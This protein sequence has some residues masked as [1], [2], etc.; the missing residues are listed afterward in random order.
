MNIFKILAN[1]HGSINENNVSAFLGYLLDP[2]GDHGLG[3]EFLEH[4]LFRVFEDEDFKFRK[5]DYEVILEQGF[6][7]KEK[8]EVV[9]IVI[10]CFS[11]NNSQ[12]SQS[13]FKSIIKGEAKIEKVFLIENKIKKS[14]FKAEQ[15]KKQFESFKNEGLDVKDEDIHSILLS[16]HEKKI[17]DTFKTHKP[18]N[19][20]HLFWK[21][22]DQEEENVTDMIKGI[23]QQVN[24]GG[25]DPINDYSLITLKSFL[26]F[27]NN[28]FKSEKIEKSERT[29][30]GTYTEQY[31]KLNSESN[32]EK[33]LDDLKNYLEPRLSN[34]DTNKIHVD[35]NEPRHPELSIHY[36]GIK[37]TVGA[38]YKSRDKVGFTYSQSEKGEDF[39]N[40]LRDLAQR[41]SVDLKKPNVKNGSYC[42]TEE[43]RKS[44]K[45]ENRELILE[46]VVEFLD[47]IK[48]VK[49]YES[50][51]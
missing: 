8:K 37:L 23:I 12:G 3:Y 30:D 42:K 1:G 13:K 41:L 14:S 50:L 27:V 33:R 4:F 34:W 2:N 29:K 36:D 20:T 35:M 38:G 46:R 39:S 5:Y 10:L 40:K 6:K 49:E 17:I 19:G 18:Q 26:Q 11:R 47:L 22:G 48:P 51:V 25:I 24:S 16:P 44:V 9:D 28:E 15:V 43:M 45:L 32:I 31:I 7:G 21:G